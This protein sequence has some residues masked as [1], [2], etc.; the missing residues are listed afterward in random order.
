MME[1]AG[2]HSHKAT[3]PAL[4]HCCCCCTWIIFLIN[5][6]FLRSLRMLG[7]V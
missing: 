2:R 4:R 7:H 5:E 1:P 6:A 3:F